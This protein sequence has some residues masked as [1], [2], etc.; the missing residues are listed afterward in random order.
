MRFVR[1]SE[2]HEGNLA[3]IGGPRRAQVVA[4]RVVK[5][6]PQAQPKPAC[7]TRVNV[8]PRSKLMFGVTLFWRAAMVLVSMTLN[9][10]ASTTWLDVPYVR[11]VKAGCGAA[12]VAM[13][14]DYWARQ[15]P[16]LSAAVRDSER[17]NDLLPAS[18]KGIR[19]LELKRYLGDRGFAA[20]VF[21]GE[22]SD[23]QHHFKKGR[24]VV[25][26]LGLKGAKGPPHYAVVVG[27]DDKAVWL[28]DSARGKLIRD[29]ISH[30]ESAW[31]VTGNWALLAVPRQA[32]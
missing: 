27:V 20:Y 24:P 22:I 4:W 10:A 12:A 28:N 21:D 13:V 15:Y 29:E 14:V 26:C 19:G 17:I 3:P 23:L 30:F 8:H 5:I 7:A 16:Q 1:R 9:M 2:P 6:N 32:P 31:R 11:Q 25:V 18:R